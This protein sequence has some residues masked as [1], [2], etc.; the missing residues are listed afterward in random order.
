MDT[1][2]PFFMECSIREHNVINKVLLIT[3]AL[4][5][6]CG[7]LFKRESGWYL[8]IDDSHEF[9]IPN[10]YNIVEHNKLKELLHTQINLFD[11]HKTNNKILVSIYLLPLV[12]VF[13][14]MVTGKIYCR[15]NIKCLTN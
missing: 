4:G 5:K 2:H 13:R 10:N 3:L 14:L 8:S 6:G 7:L 9:K 12:I 11:T 1:F 15:P